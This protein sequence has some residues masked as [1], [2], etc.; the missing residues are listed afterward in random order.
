MFTGRNTMEKSNGQLI[1]ERLRK[2][3]DLRGV[4]QVELSKAAGISKQRI[5][6]YA[7]GRSVPKTQAIFAMAK[8]LMV[9][10]TWLMGFTD[11]DGPEVSKEMDLQVKNTNDSIERSSVLDQIVANLNRMSISDLNAIKSITDR[12]VKKED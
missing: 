2:A 4:N 1:A 8:Y 6:Y 12:M 9:S 10:P 3:M 5:C 7:K 11:N